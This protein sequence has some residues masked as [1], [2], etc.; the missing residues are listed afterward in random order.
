MSYEIGMNAIHLQ[1][2]ERFAH[3]EY[4]TSYPL[5]RAVTG[6]DPQDDASAWAKFYDA[7]Q[8]DFFWSTNDGPVPW[9]ERGRTTD[10]GHAEFLEGGIDRRDAVTCPFKDVEQ[11]LSFDAA[12]EYGLTETKELV[13]FYEQSYR[14]GR[15]AHP[16]QVYTGG[17]YRTLISGAIEAFGWDMLLAAAADRDRFDRVLE[18]IFQ[19]SLHHYRAWAG[20]SIDVFICHDDMVWSQGAFMRPDFYRS[21][22]FPRYRKLWDLLHEAGKIVLFCSDGDWTQFIDDIADAG[23]DGFIFEPMTDLDYVAR[24]YGRTHSIFS[25]FVDCRTLTFGTKEQIQHEIDQTLDLA[26]GCSGFVVA[27]GNHIPS[28]VPVENALFY[29]DYLSKHWR[30]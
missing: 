17:Y 19:L 27:V 5:I 21:A 14:N 25:S 26:R 22:V 12:E 29:F 2:A 7:W 23:A 20:T 16:N 18:S 30:R 15:Q 13:A 8:F 9:A 11:V 4:C 6:V 10:M 28:N 24:H 3:T 1:P